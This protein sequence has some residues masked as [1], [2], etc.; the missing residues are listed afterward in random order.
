MNVLDTIP[1]DVKAHYHALRTLPDG[2]VIG[3][4][5]LLHHWTLHIDIDW[6]GYEDNY[7]YATC[8]KAMVGLQ[9][10]T[11]IGDPPGGWHRHTRTGRRRPDGDPLQ[12]YINL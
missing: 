7:C 5:R 3:V 11:G 2:R 6:F 4:A 12:E 1:E 8:D 10:W 9:E